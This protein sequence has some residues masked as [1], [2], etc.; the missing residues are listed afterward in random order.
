MYRISLFRTKWFGVAR[1]KQGGKGSHNQTLE[2]RREVALGY[3]PRPSTPSPPPPHTT[4]TTTRM[5]EGVGMR[6]RWMQHQMQRASGAPTAAAIWH[7]RMTLLGDATIRAPHPVLEVIL[8][9]RRNFCVW[10]CRMVLCVAVCILLPR[11]YLCLHILIYFVYVSYF[12]FF[13]IIPKTSCYPTNCPRIILRLI[14]PPS[15]RQNDEWQ[16]RGLSF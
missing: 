12:F 9:R 6:R 16:L 3:H 14:P 2:G 11:V 10:L 15:R 13:Q 1:D 8:S 5:R 4:S 7:S